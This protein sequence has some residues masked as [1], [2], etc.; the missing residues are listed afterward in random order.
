MSVIPYI[1]GFIGDLCFF[2]KMV[3]YQHFVNFCDNFHHYFKNKLPIS[4]PI[5][6]TGPINNILII[7]EN[8]GEK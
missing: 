2:I 8:T 5:L 4:S 3:F 1:I 7:K 6:G